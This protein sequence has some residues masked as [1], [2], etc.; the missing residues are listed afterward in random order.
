VTAT[1]PLRPQPAPDVDSAGFWQSLDDGALSIQRCEAC[2]EWQ[3]PPLERCRHC[4]GALRFET[5]SGTGRIHTFIV[6]HHTVVPG[7]DDERPY[8]I[9]LV[10]PDEAP[11]AR[12]PG[13]VVGAPPDGVRVDARVRVEVTPHPGGPHRVARFRLEP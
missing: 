4:D 2:R 6:Q 9:A 1:E 7:F 13:Q 5:L 10:A 3:F 8:V 11:H 12:I